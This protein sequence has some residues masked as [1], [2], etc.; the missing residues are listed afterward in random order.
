MADWQPIESAPR[1]GEGVMVYIMQRD[2]FTSA[3]CFS[4]VSITS[5]GQWW[6]DA[7][8]DAIEPLLDATHWMPLP[9]P[10]QEAGHE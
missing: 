9:P 3:H 5:D 1:T 8:G 2:K 4:P 6:D 10:P 7:T